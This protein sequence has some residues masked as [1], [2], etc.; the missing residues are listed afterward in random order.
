M[1]V[2]QHSVHVSEHCAPADA[3]WGLLHDASE[4]YIVDIPRPLKLAPGMEGYLALERKMMHAVCD[5]FGLP[6]EMP[7]SVRAAD[8]LL[9][10]SEAYALLPA[11]GEGGVARWGLTDPPSVDVVPWS[12]AASRQRFLARFRELTEWID[13]E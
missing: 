4:A 11:G 8:E 13:D 12:P 9:L 7:P 6:R 10:A 3:L 5:A 1:S 2:A